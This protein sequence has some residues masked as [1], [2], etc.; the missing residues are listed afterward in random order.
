MVDAVKKY[1][2]LTFIKLET[3]EE[4]K[5]IAREHHIE[6]ES[7]HKK[8]DIINLFFEEFVEENLVQPTFIGS[9]IRWIFR[10]WQ[11]GS[12]ICPSILKGSELFITQREMAN[13]FF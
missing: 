9:F 8:G 11:R 6:Y 12:R 5:A 10:R 3:E 13:A 1:T 4:A 2:G 7:R